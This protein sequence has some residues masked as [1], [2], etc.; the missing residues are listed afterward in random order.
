MVR[1][2]LEPDTSIFP[3]K[4]DCFFL[5]HP[6]SESC[7]QLDPGVVSCVLPCPA[8]CPALWKPLAASSQPPSGSL[9][10]CSTS[11]WQDTVIHRGRR[12]TCWKKWGNDAGRSLVD[13][14]WYVFP[15]TWPSIGDGT[16]FW[17]VLDTTMFG[18]FAR[19]VSGA[20][21]WDSVIAD[22]STL[23]SLS[24]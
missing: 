14:G 20:F 12:R 2:K 4:K 8:S 23:M 13:H 9:R 19:K 21:E 1:K 17:N 6:H 24:Q 16:Q 18:A 5:S 7:S 10:P 3:V 11:P 22:V 15:M